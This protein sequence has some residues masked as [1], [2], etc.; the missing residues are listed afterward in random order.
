MNTPKNH[1]NLKSHN[2]K[3]FHHFKKNKLKHQLKEKFWMIKLQDF[4]QENQI[5]IIL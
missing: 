5:T 4:W 2:P 1:K 3:L